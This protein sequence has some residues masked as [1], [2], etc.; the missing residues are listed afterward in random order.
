MIRTI[1]L[2][3]V[4][5]MLTAPPPQTDKP[6][7]KAADKGIT[8]KVTDTGF[9]PAQIKVKKDTPVHLIFLRTSET[10]CGTD[11]VI[12]DQKIEKSLPL[13]KPVAVDLTFKQAGEVTFTCGQKMLKGS[14]VVQSS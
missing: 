14:I 10:T 13:N 12:P 7:D 5:L 1:L 8:I 3:M 2:G 11:V 9:E 4:G 6:A